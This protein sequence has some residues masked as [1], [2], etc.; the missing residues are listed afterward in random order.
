MSSLSSK[1]DSL[2]NATVQQITSNVVTV[3]PDI[4]KKW[5]ES[6]IENQRSPS[7]RAILKYSRAMTQGKWKTASPLSFSQKGHQG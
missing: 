6:M 3:T 7:E 2:S 4:A 5:L 1:D